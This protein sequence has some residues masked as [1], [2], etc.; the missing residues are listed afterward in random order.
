MA[1]NGAPLYPSVIVTNAGAPTGCVNI[2]DEAT[3]QTVTAPATEAGYCEA[4]QKLQ[5]GK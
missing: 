4:I 5:S 3:G 1:D 2:H